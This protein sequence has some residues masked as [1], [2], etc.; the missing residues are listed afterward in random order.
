[1]SSFLHIRYLHPALC[2]SLIIS[3][4]LFFTTFP[5]P[6]Y[7]SFLPPILLVYCLSL[8]LFSPAS[9]PPSLC[10]LLDPPECGNGFVETGE[11]CDCGSQL[12]RVSLRNCNPYMMRDQNPPAWMGLLPQPYGPWLKVGHYKGTRV[13]FETDTVTVTREG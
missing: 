5:C 6:F 9:I 12:V 4:F 7:P 1:M 3:L 2:P 13:L 11:E 10:Q 8:R